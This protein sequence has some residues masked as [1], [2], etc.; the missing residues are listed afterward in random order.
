MI[1]RI[2]ICPSP[3]YGYFHPKKLISGIPIDISG[4]MQCAL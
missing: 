4:D 3:D 1:Y 2:K